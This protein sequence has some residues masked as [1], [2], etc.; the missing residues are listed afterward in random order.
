MQTTMGMFQ[1][2]AGSLAIGIIDKGRRKGRKISSQLNMP[3]RDVSTVT[4]AGG[5]GVKI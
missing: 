4:I 2:A 1:A 5:D 3:P